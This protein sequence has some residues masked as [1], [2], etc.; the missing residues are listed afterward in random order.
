MSRNLFCESPSSKQPLDRELCQRLHYEALVRAMRGWPVEAVPSTIDLPLLR[1]RAHLLGHDVYLYPPEAI[2]HIFAGI[3]IGVY[4]TVVDLYC[5]RLERSI[6]TVWKIVQALAHEAGTSDISYEAV[7]ALCMHLEEHRQHKTKVTIERDGATWWV[8]LL[9]CE[10]ADQGEAES[11]TQNLIV[12]LID[13]PREAV[14]AFRVVNLQHISDAYGL[15]LYDA[16]IQQRRPG[17][18][19]AAGLTWLMP[20]Q[21]IVAG[22]LPQ[23]CQ[24]GCARLGIHLEASSEVPAFFHTLQADFRREINRRVLRKD[25]WAAAFDSYLHKAYG[26]SPVRS[27]E[28]RDHEHIHLIGYNRDPAWQFPALRHFLPLRRGSITQDGAVPYDGLHF[29]DKLL[30]YWTGAPVTFRQSEQMEALI[31]VYL[32]GDLLCSAM[33]Q[34]LQRRDGSYRPHRPRR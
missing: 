19:A 8:T 31:W 13:L 12:C 7:W 30:V 15:V 6:N 4:R 26:Y 5:S 34:E 21:L 24:E 3:S 25:R 28:E 18:D 17:R 10:E 23:N 14:L 29:T 27:R 11:N 33:A 9:H 32:D 16:F 1:Q 20:E 2:D 22:N